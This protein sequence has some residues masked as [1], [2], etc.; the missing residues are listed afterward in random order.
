MG[1]GA[2][3]GLCDA[4][5]KLHAR[6]WRHGDLKPENILCFDDAR[7]RPGVLV[8]ADVGLLRVQSVD[9]NLKRTDT[10]Y[11]GHMVLLSSSRQRFPKITPIRCLVDGRYHPRNH[12]L[13]FLRSGGGSK[14]A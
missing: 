11:D 9:T 6:N 2:L 12:Y 3:E 4:L 5:Q 13:H 14:T 8:I 1:V 10:D 7:T